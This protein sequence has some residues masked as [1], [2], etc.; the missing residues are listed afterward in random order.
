MLLY[1][2]DDERREFALG[3]ALLKSD[4]LARTRSVSVRGRTEPSGATVRAAARTSPLAPAASPADDIE[5]DP[6]LLL[7]SLEA[8][9]DYQANLRVLQEA[10]LFRACL[11]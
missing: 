6:T 4:A 11:P 2:N 8:L 10:D 7:E 3:R 1:P 9:A 5:H